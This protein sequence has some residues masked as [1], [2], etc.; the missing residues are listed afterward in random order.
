MATSA[1]REAVAVEELE[2]PTMLV[3]LTGH[4]VTLFR[5]D[6]SR[7]TLPAGP[8][9][10]RLAEEVGR[11]LGEIAGVPVLERGLGEGLNIP[12]AVAGLFYIVPFL[13]AVQYLERDD[14][15][16]PDN[17]VRENGKVVGARRLVRLTFRR[18]PTG[19]CR[20]VVA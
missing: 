7:Y 14:L 20:G 11:P 6:G 2:S 18:R 10:V 4:A 13:V 12:P 16:V 17:L 15:L 5:P 1:E 9:T 19:H 8:F 3:N